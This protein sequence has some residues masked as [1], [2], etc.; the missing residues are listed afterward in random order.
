MIK[1]TTNINLQ[2]LI[3]EPVMPHRVN[4]FFEIY[5][6]NIEGFF[7]W[8]WTYLSIKVR[9]VKTVKSQF[10][11]GGVSSKQRYARRMQKKYYG[12]EWWMSENHPYLLKYMAVKIFFLEIS[13]ATVSK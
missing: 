12:V 1:T 5:K 3:Q 13:I 4:S 8:L 9:R 2:R 10:E 11:I 6:T 7:L